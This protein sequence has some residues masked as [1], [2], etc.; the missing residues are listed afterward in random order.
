MTTVKKDTTKSAAPRQE[1]AGQEFIKPANPSALPFEKIGDTFTGKVVDVK[2]FQLR[3]YDSKEPVF[4][5]DGEP[6]LGLA[7]ILMRE[8]NGKAATFYV[9]SWTKKRALGAAFALLEISGFAPGDYI[10][11]TY[12]GNKKTPKGGKAKVYDIVI[13]LA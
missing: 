9:D 2:S 5:D 12:T 6:L 11:I 4:T 1:I 3:N 7:V 13:S 8:D 10:S